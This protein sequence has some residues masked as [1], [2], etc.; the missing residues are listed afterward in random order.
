M[1]VLGRA[2]VPLFRRVAGLLFLALAAL[3]STQAGAEVASPWAQGLHSRVRLVAD[4]DATG[5]LGEIEA[6]SEIGTL[7]VTMAGRAS[8]NAKTS[9]S[10]AYSL[11]HAILSRGAGLVI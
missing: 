5:N 2:P 10:V 7:S 11:L 1:H 8:A 3:G 6:S 9:A 4:P